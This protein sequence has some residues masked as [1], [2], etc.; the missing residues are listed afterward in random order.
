[1]NE[2]QAF[3]KFTQADKCSAS[4]FA[5]AKKY[6]KEHS[7]IEVEQLFNKL[8]A[9]VKNVLEE[10]VNSN[11]HSVHDAKYIYETMKPDIIDI[12]MGC[13]VPK[14]AVKAQAGSALLKHPEKVKEI[15]KAVVDIVPI[16]INTNKINI[17]IK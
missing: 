14:V 13:P 3:V 4:E 12:N 8:Y 7:S 1:M 10:T 6:A 9:I 17:S 16:P 5:L 15:V 11:Y 2:K